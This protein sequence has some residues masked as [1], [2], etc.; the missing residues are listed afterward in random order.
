M[1]EKT[2]QAVDSGVKVQK[3]DTAI[4]ISKNELIGIL[5]KQKGHTFIQ[6]FATTDV[7]MNKGGRENSNYLYG[8]VIKDS[9]VNG[10]V[11]FE[12]ENA[13]N[14]ALKREGKNP[15]YELGKRA[16][17][18]HMIIDYVFD[19]ET[20]EFTPVYSRILIEYIKDGEKRYY[21]QMAVQSAKKPTY[22]YKDT[23][24]VLSEKDIEVMKSYISDK[25]EELVVVRDYRVDNVT[26]IHINKGQYILNQNS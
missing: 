12:Y 16:W 26:R 10:G 4:E 3:V 6:L 7:K 14:N 17:G 19:I 9:E 5:I 18:E 20:L 8:N 24:E 11:D 15:D 13:V 2:K 22:R 23:G 25:K 1:V 21:V